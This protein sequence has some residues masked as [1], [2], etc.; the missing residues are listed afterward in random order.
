MQA[1]DAP[2]VLRRKWYQEC[3]TSRTE[4]PHYEEN[5]VELTAYLWKMW[6]E[7]R[8]HIDLLRER[9]IPIDGVGESWVWSLCLE[10]PFLCHECVLKG[11]PLRGCCPADEYRWVRDNNYIDDEDYR[12]MARYCPPLP[13]TAEPP[14]W[15]DDKPSAR[16]PL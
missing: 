6:L 5:C 1:V 14:E 7:T 15:E 13:L 16:L 9:G 4:A 11:G 8:L 10:N 2:I 3:T 12:R